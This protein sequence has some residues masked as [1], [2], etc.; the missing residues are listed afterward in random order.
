MANFIEIPVD[1]LE[2]ATLQALL[3]EFASRDGTDY[4]AVE[5]VLDRKVAQL[6]ACLETGEMALLYDSECQQWDLLS[7]ESAA[8]YL[9]DCY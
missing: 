5:T 4:G 9:A 3:E 7:R 6:L 8:E 1:Q 2:S